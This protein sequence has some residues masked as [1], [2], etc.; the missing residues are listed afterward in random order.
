M[1]YI[2]ILAIVSLMTSVLLGSLSQSQAKLR[3]ANEIN[4]QGMVILLDLERTV[5]NAEVINSP[6]PAGSS[7]YLDVLLTD[8][9]ATQVQYTVVNGVLG[10]SE[11]G[12]NW[13]AL[14]NSKVKVDDFSLREVSGG[15]E[16][17]AVKF[18]FTLSGVASSSRNEHAYTRTFWGSA[19]RH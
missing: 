13:T 17:A 19:T 8:M 7:D 12:L 4:A 18:E 3:L 5:R 14:S 6:A 9:A 10:K 16:A 11:G 15:A 2:A 1:L